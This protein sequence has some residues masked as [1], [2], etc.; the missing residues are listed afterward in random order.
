IIVRKLTLNRQEFDTSK[1]IVIISYATYP[2]N[3]PR[4][5]RTHQLTKELSRRGYDVT[6]YVLTSDYDYRD[7]LGNN[8]IKVKSLGKTYFFKYSHKTGATLNFPM[9]VI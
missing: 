1:K 3:A 4:Q 9:K 2:G 7:Y 6:L 8:N 5:I